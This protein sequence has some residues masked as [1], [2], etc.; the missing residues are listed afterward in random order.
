MRKS[1][2]TPLGVTPSARDAELEN[3]LR[4]EQ[5][6]REQAAARARGVPQHTIDAAKAIRLAGE[7]TKGTISDAGSAWLDRHLL[8]RDGPPP[9]PVVASLDNERA[10]RAWK[11]GRAKLGL[12]E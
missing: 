6:D 4:Q 1:T 3:L 2:L 8:E 12:E 11:S 7:R 9:G 5:E 10:L